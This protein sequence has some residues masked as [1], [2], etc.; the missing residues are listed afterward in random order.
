M[1]V[2]VDLSDLLSWPHQHLT[3]IQRVVAEVSALSIDGH[4]V[5]EMVE[6]LETIRKPEV[7][8]SLIEKGRSNAVRFSREKNLQQFYAAITY[9][10]PDV[11]AFE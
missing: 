2:W 11:W 9:N 1:R 5:E 6:A 4:S 7:R 10:L 8:A 3:G